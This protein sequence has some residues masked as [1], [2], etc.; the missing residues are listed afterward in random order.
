MDDSNVL[1]YTD[2]QIRK[3]V[4]SDGLSNRITDVILHSDSE[5]DMWVIEIRYETVN[6]EKKNFFMVKSKESR[7]ANGRVESEC[8]GGWR[9]YC[10][11]NGCCWLAGGG[12]TFYCQY[13]TDPL[14]GQLCTL[15]AECEPE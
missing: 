6:S 11:G 10:T 3:Y 7:L 15:H 1:V 8:P 13:G 9:Y 5:P 14:G 2:A 12:S 4:A